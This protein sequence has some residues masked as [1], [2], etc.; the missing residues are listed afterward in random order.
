MRPPASYS[1]PAGASASMLRRTVRWLPHRRAHGA[2]CTASPHAGNDRVDEHGD[3]IL[4]ASCDG[5]CG[6]GA[7]SDHGHATGSGG[8]IDQC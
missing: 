7:G 8:A 3:S 4:S 1:L 2:V 6:V 5:T